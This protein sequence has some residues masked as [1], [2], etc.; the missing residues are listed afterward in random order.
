MRFDSPIIFK[1]YSLSRT[2]IGIC[3]IKA[4]KAIVIANVIR[5]IVKCLFTITPK[6]AKT[7]IVPIKYTNNTAPEGSGT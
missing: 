5:E 2:V 7:V 4:E 3:T 6:E 1:K